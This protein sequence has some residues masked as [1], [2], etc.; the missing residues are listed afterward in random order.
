MHSFQ[1]LTS[2]Y[3]KAP[4]WAGMFFIFHMT[5]TPCSPIE[6]MLPNYLGCQP[7]SRCPTESAVAKAQW[8][9]KK[10]KKKQEKPV[11][12]S[13]VLL[14]LYDIFWKDRHNL[15]AKRLSS[16]VKPFA[17]HSMPNMF[18][19]GNSLFSVLFSFLPNFTTLKFVQLFAF[20]ICHDT[21][22]LAVVFFKLFDDFI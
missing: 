10:K 2:S 18:M 21:Y 1:T 20:W 4:N 3:V 13:K 7:C 16:K 17:H 5:G 6:T 14:L 11:S 8:P 22:T 9:P 15:K 12:I 19:D